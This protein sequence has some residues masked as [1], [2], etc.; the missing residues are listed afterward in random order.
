MHAAHRTRT[1]RNATERPNASTSR[2]PMK[3]RAGAKRSP[4]AKERRHQRAERQDATMSLRD[5]RLRAR[6]LAEEALAL[7]RQD[8]ELS[9]CS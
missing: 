9:S 1:A 5:E 6:R 4:A 7:F 2:R 8:G 3:R